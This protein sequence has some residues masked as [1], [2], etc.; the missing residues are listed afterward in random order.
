MPAEVTSLRV[1]PPA[2]PGSGL[3]RPPTATVARKIRTTV[4]RPRVPPPL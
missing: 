1:S 2:A 4:R 3:F